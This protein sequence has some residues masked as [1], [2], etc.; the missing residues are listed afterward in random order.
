[1]I[2]LDRQKDWQ[3]DGAGSY[4]DETYWWPCVD[5]SPRNEKNCGCGFE[6]INNMRKYLNA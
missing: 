1:M 3:A 4:L 2:E 6:L 5:K